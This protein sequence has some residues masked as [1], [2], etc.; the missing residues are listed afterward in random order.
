MIASQGFERQIAQAVKEP[1]R[2]PLRF[3]RAPERVRG[4][5]RPDGVSEHVDAHAARDRRRQRLL[6]GDPDSVVAQD[7]RLEQYLLRR[8]VDRGQHG[9]KGEFPVNQQAGAGT[10]MQRTPQD[11]LRQLAKRF[12]PH[13]LREA[14]GQRP[15]TIHAQ[16]ARRRISGHT[17]A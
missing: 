4:C 13:A 10:R 3:P 11:L 6:H 2:D 17:A 1:E 7:I 15:G 12:V 8:L 5:Q 16:L 14:M 9:A